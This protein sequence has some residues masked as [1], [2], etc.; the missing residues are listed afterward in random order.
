LL[1]YWSYMLAVFLF[2][3][4]GC[5][6]NTFYTLRLRIPYISLLSLIYL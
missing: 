6:D 2:F 1:N 5:P 4:L 3:Y